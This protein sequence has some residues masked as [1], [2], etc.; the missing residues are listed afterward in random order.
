MINVGTIG[1]C[2]YSP[3]SI[4]YRGFDIRFNG[5]VTIVVC[6][7]IKLNVSDLAA[8]E[9]IIDLWICENIKYQGL[10]LSDISGMDYISILVNR[11]VL[12]SEPPF[13]IEQDVKPK[14]DHTYKPPKM[15]RQVRPQQPQRRFNRHR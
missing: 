11:P 2:D 12:D 13:V 10:L 3:R 1:H 5:R 9:R 14:Q 7:N 6:Q 4:N 8:A 15:M